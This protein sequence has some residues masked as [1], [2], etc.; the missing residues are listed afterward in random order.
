MYAITHMQRFGIQINTAK[1]KV[2]V[3]SREL[4]KVNIGMAGDKF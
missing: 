4:R 1:T 3:I 2:M